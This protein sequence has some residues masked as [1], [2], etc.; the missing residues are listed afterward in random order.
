MTL[1]LRVSPELAA[2]V[3]APRQQSIA[4]AT[5]LTIY[6]QAGNLT[7]KARTDMPAAMVVNGTSYE[8]MSNNGTSTYASNAYVREEPSQ[9]QPL[10]ISS[11]RHTVEQMS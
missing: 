2:S 5:V 7:S 4:A 10:T 3:A 6:T 1:C 9:G 11:P 8:Q